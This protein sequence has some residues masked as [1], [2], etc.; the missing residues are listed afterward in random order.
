MSNFL[1]KYK[2]SKIFIFFL[3]ILCPIFSY[4]VVNSFC[5]N[6]IKFKFI[7]FMFL[8]EFLCMHLY[9]N[10]KII[11]NFIYKYRY[12]IGISLFSVLVAF[13]FHGSSSG[14]YENFIEPNSSTSS[15]IPIF[16]KNRDIRSD[17]WVVSTP[18]VLSQNSI[19]NNYNTFNVTAAA[20]LT[21]V[22]FYPK[23]P[24]KNISILASPKY[25]GFLF[26]PLENA[27]SFYWYFNIFAIF[28]ITFE[29]FMI[30]TKNNKIWS[31]TG[32]IMITFG[33]SVQWWYSNMLVEIIYSGL[34]ALVLFYN[35]LHSKN[36]FYKILLS[37]GIGIF[38]SIFIQ[39]LYP[40]W[41]VLFAYIYLAFIIYFII[42]KNNNSKWYDY[43][44][45]V[46]ITVITIG[47]ILLPAIYNSID[48]VRLTMNTVYPGARFS[49]GGLGFEHL[50]DYIISIAL[51]YISFSNSSE[52]SQF[53]SLYP[54]PLIIGLIVIIQNFKNKKNDLLLIL[55]EIIILFFSLWNYI[56]LP[57]FISKITFL[58]MS[59]EQRSTVVVSFCCV[60][61]LIY[62]LSNYKNILRK[63]SILY[64]CFA[65]TIA[66]FGTY[67]MLK[68]YPEA[69]KKLL[70]YGFIMIV[71]SLIYLILC[72]SYCKYKYMLPLALIIVTLFSG[73]TVN[74]L[75]RNLNV[76]Y[77]KPVSKK[78][79][80]IFSDDNEAIWASSNA[81]IFYS[82]YLL[83]NGVKT[84]N[85][86]HYFPYYSI[87]NIIDPSYKY[88]DVWNRYA[89]V[90]VTL[91]NE[92]TSVQLMQNDYININL[93][94]EDVCKLNI[95][96][97][98]SSDN[99]LE[100]YSNS[101]IKINKIYENENVYIYENKCS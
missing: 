74:P 64:F 28:F 76:F 73:L 84:F 36:L 86:V 98:M 51:P 23:M 40:A 8:L 6:F 70:I 54:V 50:F 58:Y 75:N 16:G 17:E 59:T 77:E 1:K 63:N 25:L 2:Y 96:Y 42:D 45:L 39:I 5:I 49:Q 13:G 26:L 78:I 87:W 18:F 38:G 27:F 29:F 60:V 4:L 31:L 89:H 61:L 21:N 52:A 47:L 97:L 20:S 79:N 95:K 30:I 90:T 12:I 37:I 92:N 43:F 14:L 71:T 88:V 85:S 81:P 46:F 34:G 67:I 32:A 56:K 55:L 100:S 41:M 48:N 91:T 53:L 24:S 82:D 10:V 65:F 101:K 44:M 72:Y 11:W 83:A 15:G 33:P 57:A 99:N 93:R 3:I 80:D 62:V 94:N 9:I 19:L 7:F 68:I 35:F 69:D 22:S 66:C